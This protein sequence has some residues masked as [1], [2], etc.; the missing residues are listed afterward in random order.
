MS[1]LTER[2]AAYDAIAQIVHDYL[3]TGTPITAQI[4]FGTIIGIVDKTDAV[5]DLD[6]LVLPLAA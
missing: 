5:H 4:A 2:A 3:P 6:Q 1:T